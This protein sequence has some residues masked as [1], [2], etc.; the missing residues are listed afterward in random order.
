MIRHCSAQEALDLEDGQEESWVIKA[1]GKK[2]LEAR[3]DQLR[4]T[5]IVHRLTHRTFTSSQWQELRTQ[6]AAWK[7]GS[8]ALHVSL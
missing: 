2:L 3:I 8:F 4:R 1:S 6:L 5:V 7:V